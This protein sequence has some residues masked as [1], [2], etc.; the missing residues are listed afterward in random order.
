MKNKPV[1]IVMAAGMGSRFGGL[2]QITPVTP[3]GDLILDFSIHDATLAGFETVIFIIKRE[4]EDIFRSV[5]GNRLENKINVKY[6]YQELDDLPEGFNVPEDRV[7]P[8]GTG[9]AVLAC[10]N[11]VNSAFAVI[12]ADDYYGRE[13]FKL[14]YDYLVAGDSSTGRYAMVSYRLDKTVTEHGH[15]ARGVCSVSQD[16]L[17]TGIVERTRIEKRE[18]N[19]I[20]YTEDDGDSWHELSGSTQVSM[21][22]WGFS[23]DM[24]QELSDRFPSFLRNELSEN[25]LK[26]EYFLPGVV[27]QVLQEKR[28]SVRVLPSP[29]SWY[30]VTYQ[31]DKP[32]VTEALRELKIQGMYPGLKK[33]G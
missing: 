4:M 27:D 9:H 24:M 17:L 25:P 23:L 33:R 11:I 31:E 16:N 10:R 19:V 8:F 26:A 15:V 22:F 12:N 6:A 14:I 1:L 3:E 13:G 28:A 30:G 29:D 18:N 5:V 20:A 32:Q 21:N 2:K 7:K